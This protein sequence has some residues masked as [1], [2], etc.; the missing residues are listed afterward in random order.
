MLWVFK[1]NKKRFHEVFSSWI[2]IMYFS[3]K[4]TVEFK[5]NKVLYRNLV[6]QLVDKRQ[7]SPGRDV[8]ISILK[9][10]FSQGCETRL[11]FAPAA[12][13]NSN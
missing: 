3:L 10:L 6:K 5:N 11:G 13:R 9:Q 1:K 7:N 12:F 2:S 4:N 8:E